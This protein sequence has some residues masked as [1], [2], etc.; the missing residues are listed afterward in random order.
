MSRPPLSV[1]LY[2]VRAA[3]ERDLPGTLARLAQLGFTQVE[4]YG[5][6]QRETAFAEGLAAAGLT[7][8]S[9]HAS[10]VRAD[11]PASTIAR[12]ARLGL[13]TVIDPMVPSEHWTTREAIEATAARLNELALVGAD[14]GVRIGYHNH[15]WELA[16][17]IDGTPALE[18]LADSLDAAIALEVDTYWVEV[19]GV[20]APE[21]LQRLGDRVTHLHVKDGPVSRDT[22]AQTAVG[23][24]RIDVPAI[25]AAA[26]HAQPVVELDDFDGDVFDALADS[27]AY[28][29]SGVRA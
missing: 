6:D 29:E 26:P 18:V 13:A 21:L 23:A 16:N 7:A 22:K 24:G 1:Q 25:L 28:L 11:D 3:I 2:T 8:P 19:G 5:F 12:A 9:G 4:L 10:L 27:I 20:F 17:R 15:E 14:H